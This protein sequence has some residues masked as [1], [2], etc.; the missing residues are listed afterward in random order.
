MVGVS[1]RRSKDDEKFIQLIM[2]A[3]AQSHK[4]YIMDAR[5]QVNALANKVIQR[6]AITLIFWYRH[7]HTD[8]CMHAR[9]VLM[10]LV[11]LILLLTGITHWK[12]MWRMTQPRIQT[13]IICSL[14]HNGG[15][16][17]VEHMW[18]A[19]QQRGMSRDRLSPPDARCCTPLKHR[20]HGIQ[21][22]HSQF[23]HGAR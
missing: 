15:L 21:C 6:T 14:S 7:V 2:D 22:L 5:P 20:R 8:I 17:T 9:A 3:N 16:L 10:I 12:W 1:G 18:H 23:L 13:P 19:S 11:S 4:L